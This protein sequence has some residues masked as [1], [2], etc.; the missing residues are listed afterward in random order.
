[1]VLVWNSF[2]QCDEPVNRA[3]NNLY[4]EMLPDVYPP[5]DRD[6]NEG[7]LA[8]LAG[9]EREIQEDNRFVLWFLKRYMTVYRY[10]AKSYPALLN[11]YPKI[12]KL[13]E[14]RHK[15]F[16]AK[17]EDVVG[18]YGSVCVPVQTTLL[19]CRRKDHLMRSL[20]CGYSEGF[21]S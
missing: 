16:L 21:S 7:V 2:L 11:T 19:I 6:V 8:K 15:K 4:T 17:V 13:E 18:I 14:S 10:D 9:R 3:I 1:M 20:S 5:S 12:I